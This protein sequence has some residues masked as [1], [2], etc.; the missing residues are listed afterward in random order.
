MFSHHLKG[1]GFESSRRIK[2]TIIDAPFQGKLG[3]DNERRLTQLVRCFPVTQK[4]DRGF[5]SLI[6]KKNEKNIINDPLDT[7]KN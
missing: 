4:V 7:R 3:H 5:Q 1:R 6:L 2:T